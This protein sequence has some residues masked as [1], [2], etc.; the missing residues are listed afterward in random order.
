[1]VMYLGRMVELSDTQALFEAPLHPYTKVLTLA[2]PKLDPRDRSKRYAIEGELPSPINVPSGCTFHPRC[3]YCTEQC[4][5][6]E[7]RAAR[8]AAGPLRGLPPP[9]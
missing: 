1:M 8:G 6:E 7:P 9:R 4:R 2:A 3:A 5:R